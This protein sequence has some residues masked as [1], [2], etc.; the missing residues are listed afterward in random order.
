LETVPGKGSINR[1]EAMQLLR[2]APQVPPI[3]KQL[4]AEIAETAKKNSK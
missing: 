1:S 3:R 2:S 4:T